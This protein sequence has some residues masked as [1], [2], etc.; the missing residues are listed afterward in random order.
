[1]SAEEGDNVFTFV[2]W[3]VGLSVCLFISLFFCEHDYTKLCGRIIGFLCNLVGGTRPWTNQL[4]FGINPFLDLDT[5]SVFPFFQHGEIH[6]TFFLT[7]NRII[8][9]SCRRVL[10]IE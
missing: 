8:S 9:K 7:L 4:D 1:M 2:G 6:P 10:A 3:L 5:R